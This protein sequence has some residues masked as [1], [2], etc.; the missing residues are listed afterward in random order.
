M[1]C[2]ALDNISNRENVILCCR[3]RDVMAAVDWAVAEFDWVDPGRIAA[4]GASY[5]GYMMNWINGH[6]NRFDTVLLLQNCPS[7][8]PSP[9][10][11]VTFCH[12]N[13]TLHP[14]RFKCLVAHG[15]IFSLRNLYYTTEELWCAYCIPPPPKGISELKK[16]FCFRFPEWEFGL[17]FAERKDGGAGGAGEAPG[18]RPASDYE[19]FSPDAHVGHW[20]T[21]TLVIHGGKDYRLFQ[22]SS[23]HNFVS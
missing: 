3:Y 18:Q 6:T 4:L 17:P 9:Q 1:R 21:P 13:V 22:D 14:Y 15:A 2:S 16:P 12:L 19:K 8:I 11:S 23:L 20:N 7:C 5:G 10:A